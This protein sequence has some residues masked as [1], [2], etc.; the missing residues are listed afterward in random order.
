MKSINPKVQKGT[1]LWNKV[2]ILDF[3]KVHI[4]HFFP[5]SFIKWCV[6]IFRVLGEFLNFHF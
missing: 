2:Q 6:K 3:F 4:V 1:G 5:V